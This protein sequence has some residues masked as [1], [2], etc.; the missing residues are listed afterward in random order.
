MK[1]R[2]LFLIQLNFLL[3]ISNPPSNSVEEPIKKSQ[4]PIPLTRLS[5]GGSGRRRLSSR[6][7]QSNLGGSSSLRRNSLSA[8]RQSLNDGII[9]YRQNPEFL[10]KYINVKTSSYFVWRSIWDDCPGHYYSKH[11]YSLFKKLVLTEIN[12]YRYHHRVHYLLPS[13]EL[14]TIAQKLAEKL[15]LKG[16]IN[17]HKDKY[18]KYGILS[19]QTTKF[20]SSTVVKNW[21]D[22]KIKYDF[23][24]KG[25]LSYAAHSFAQIVWKG[26]HKIGIGVNEV[27]GNVT[28]VILFY[29]KG[30]THLQ[31][32]K[33]V[34][35]KEKWAGK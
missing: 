11:H 29:P 35:Q 13:H 32:K 17:T 34:F 22:T 15:A 27:N 10:K 25:P 8:S 2:V 19:T 7:S 21:Y 20:L 5:G 24:L 31:Y 33:N 18:S 23:L 12:T 4:A 26:S 28:V 3:S 9:C 14:Y 1:L 6:G 30:N 16:K